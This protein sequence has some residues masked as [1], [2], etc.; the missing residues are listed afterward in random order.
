MFFS[1]RYEVR[2]KLL[3]LLRNNNN[4]KNR[5]GMILFYFATF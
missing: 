4:V 2:F 3:C 1:N 5:K